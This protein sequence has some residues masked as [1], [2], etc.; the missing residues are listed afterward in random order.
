MQLTNSLKSLIAMQMFAVIFRT[1]TK[2]TIA[3]QSSIIIKIKKS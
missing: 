3:K 1:K 2:S